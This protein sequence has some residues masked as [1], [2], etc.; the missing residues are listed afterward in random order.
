MIKIIEGEECFYLE[1]C[2]HI[3]QKMVFWTSVGGEAL[4]L[5]MFNVPMLGKA[6]TGG[7]EWVAWENTVLEVGDE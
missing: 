1:Q 2:L 4:V 6:R 3:W 7:W 5:R